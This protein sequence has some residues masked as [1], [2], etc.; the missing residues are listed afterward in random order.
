MHVEYCGEVK[1]MDNGVKKD[2]LFSLIN[3]LYSKRATYPENSELSGK[4]WMINRFLSMD[5]DMLE[6]IA[7][8]SKY[9]Y[10]LKERYY[11]LLYRIIP[12]SPS[13]RIKYF[14][15]TKEFDSELVERYSKFFNLNNR[16]VVDYLKI[17]KKDFSDRELYE[18]VGLEYKKEK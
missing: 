2:N 9:F 8:I 7:V 16:E 13:P 12:M 3:N 5:K 17:M 15:P 1:I 11:K 10:S 18:N 14:K 6:V 4:M